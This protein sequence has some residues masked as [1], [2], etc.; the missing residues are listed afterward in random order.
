MQLAAP[1]HVATFEV[2]CCADSCALFTPSAVAAATA[3]C[4]ALVF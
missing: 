3:S 4:R 2:T 1:I